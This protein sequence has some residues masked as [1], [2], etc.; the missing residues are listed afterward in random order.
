[1]FRARVGNSPA[2]PTR[3]KNGLW[4]HLLLPILAMLFWLF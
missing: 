3:T 4:I 1:M 2:I